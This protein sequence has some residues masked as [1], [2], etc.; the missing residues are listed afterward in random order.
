MLIEPDLKR[1][2]MLR[3]TY[4]DLRK[5]Q[6]SCVALETPEA[7]RKRVQELKVLLSASVT[8]TLALDFGR[9]RDEETKSLPAVGKPEGESLFET[10]N[11][12]E[13]LVALL[14]D[15]LRA[16]DPEVLKE[17]LR[18]LADRKHK[19]IVV[20]L[21]RVEML[22]VP[23]L[24]LLLGFRE[25]CQAEKVGYGLCGLPEKLRS[26]LEELGLAKLPVIYPSLQEALTAMAGACG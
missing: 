19:A 13:T 8:D 14:A 6:E 16:N 1:E 7:V 11:E 12:A 21:S 4:T 10:R 2:T 20:D 23:A 15:P 22:G 17:G 5:I 26:K 25:Q 24:L 9:R 18:L 3:G